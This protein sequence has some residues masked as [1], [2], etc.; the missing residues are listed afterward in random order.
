MIWVFLHVNDGFPKKT[1]G[2]GGGVG[3]WV[4]W[5]LAKFILDLLNLFNFAKP[6]TLHCAIVCHNVLRAIL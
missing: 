5:A 3:G 2:W 1:F 6:L 4:G